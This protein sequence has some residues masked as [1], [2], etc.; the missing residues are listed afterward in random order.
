MK[1]S[2]SKGEL[3]LKLVEE[4]IDA[5][6]HLR[7]VGDF[8]CGADDPL[9]TFLKSESF[10]YHQQK[11]GYTYLIFTETQDELLSFYTIKANGVLMRQ[12]CI[13][14]SV[15]VIEIARIA[16]QYEYQGHGL[17]KEIFFKYILPKI[18]NVAEII[19][20]YGIIV[21]VEDGNENAIKFYKSLGFIPAPQEI[22]NA[23]GE[24]FNEGCQLYFVR[25]DNVNQSLE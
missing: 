13:Y 14:N 8:Y 22:Q 15:P 1:K 16:V 9:D 18:Q 10:R 5:N 3:K 17:G 23:I 24:S 11:Y 19:A 4:A 2:T 20:I 7:I 12:D 21:F 25:L 6:K